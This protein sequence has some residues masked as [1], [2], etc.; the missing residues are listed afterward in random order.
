[1][2]TSL[3]LYT[4]AKIPMVGLGTWTGFNHGEVEQ[5][6]NVALDCGY[7]H[8]D[9]AYAYKTE[10]EIGRGLKGRVGKDIEREDVFITS[11]LWNT[12]HAAED[13]KPV[14]QQTLKD[15]GLDY[16]DMYLMHWPFAFRK[17][18]PGY[19]PTSDMQVLF[20]KTPDG[21][22]ACIDISF[23][24]T[25]SAMEK[26]V[27][28]GLCKHIG[29]SNFNSKQIIK[30]LENC[31]IKPAV[32]QIEIHPYLNQSKL[33]NFC[34]E[35]GIVVSAYSPLGAPYRILDKPRRADILND[36]ILKSIGEKYNKTPAQVSLRS[37]VQRGVTVI[38]KSENPLRIAE[39]I[40]IFDFELSEKD[41]KAIEGVQKGESARIYRFLTEV[42][43]ELVKVGGSEYPFDEEF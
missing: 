1:M 35:Q 33:I 30:V 39:N 9:G 16:L 21:T 20:P 36:P 22:L 18:V 29:L 34:K 2:A 11:K 37:I 23:L 27:D 8:F 38:P 40:Q 26:L 31:R 4:G 17:V 32:L 7:R 15:L 3:E 28:E 12:M 10:E 5:S 19:C 14:C 24:E 42:N 41:M 13:V 6:V 43:G 25:W